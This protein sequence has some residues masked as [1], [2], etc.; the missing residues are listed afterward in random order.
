MVLLCIGIAART[1]AG[2]VGAASFQMV[3]CFLRLDGLEDY[4]VA[5]SPLYMRPF[6]CARK[7]L[8]SSVI[9]SFYE[10]PNDVMV[11]SQ[12]SGHSRSRV[13]FLML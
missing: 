10:F 8:G 12:S 11:P 1:V 9:M 7:C 13:P 6:S 3:R 2:L 4:G 5:C